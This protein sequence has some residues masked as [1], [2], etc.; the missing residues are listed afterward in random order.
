MNEKIKEYHLSRKAI[1]YIRQSSQH[2]VD[3]NKESRRLQY[4]MATRLKDLGWPEADIIDEDLGKSASGAVDRSR[5]ERMVAEVCLGQVGAVAARE[6][7]RFARNNHDWQQLIEVRHA[8]W[9]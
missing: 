4:A 6:V 9:Q 1:L 5:F 3:N 8:S 7:S 2:Q